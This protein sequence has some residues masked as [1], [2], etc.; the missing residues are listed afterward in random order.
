MRVTG[1]IARGRRLRSPVAGARPTSDLVREA[2]FDVLAA[3]GFP[4][5]P[6]LDLYAGSGALGIEALSRG[7]T[8]CDFIER[9]GENLSVIKENL[10][11]TGL[12]EGG[13][14]IKSN[15]KSASAKLGE[16]YALILA[17]PPYD[18]LDAV[19]AI[20]HIARER[21]APEGTLILEQS[22]RNEAPNVV[23]ALARIWTRRYGDT[24]ISIYRMNE[25]P[26]AIDEE[27]EA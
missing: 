23:A 21:L 5:S 26:E 7:A 14:A 20:A 27:G 6:A 15:V 1:G 2:I 9:N 13:K 3:R 12:A 18:D 4:L 11:A 24:Q 25:P 8:R 22:S 17:D 19:A 10:R 16:S